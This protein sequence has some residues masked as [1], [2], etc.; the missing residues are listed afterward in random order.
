MKK[1]ILIA[2][3]LLIVMAAA[4]SKP[5]LNTPNPTN[6]AGKWCYTCYQCDVYNNYILIKS[7]KE[8]FCDSAKYKSRTSSPYPLVYNCTHQ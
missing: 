6:P 7:T 5:K 3:T 8:S 4:C 2:L 1:I